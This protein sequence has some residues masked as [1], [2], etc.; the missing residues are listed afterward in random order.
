MDD[1]EAQEMPAVNRAA[2]EHSVEALLRWRAV[3][4][5]PFVERMCA[6]VGGAEEQDALFTLLARLLDMIP[7]GCEPMEADDVA[8]AEA[9]IRLA[10]ARRISWLPSGLDR[11]LHHVWDGYKAVVFAA[12][13]DPEGQLRVRY[14]FCVALQAANDVY[15]RT[16]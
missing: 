2:V 15:F 13:G 10:L 8:G 16:N 1:L 4:Q 3:G 6:L 5:H 9:E 12:V 7:V 14:A 11:R